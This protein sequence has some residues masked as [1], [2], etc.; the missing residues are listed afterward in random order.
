[1]V[2]F[3]S[4]FPD[5]REL[6]GGTGSQLTASTTIQSPHTARFRYDAK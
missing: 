1:M 5:I 4:K 2:V 3:P 6:L